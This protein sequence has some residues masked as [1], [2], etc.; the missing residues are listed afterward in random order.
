MSNGWKIWFG[1]L[2]L[3]ALAGVWLVINAQEAADLNEALATEAPQQTVTALW[4]LR[5]LMTVVIFELIVLVV[6]VLSVGGLMSVSRAQPA[7]GTARHVSESTEP[8]K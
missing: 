1:L 7:P 3:G 2:G 4:H 6:A 8:D 5:D